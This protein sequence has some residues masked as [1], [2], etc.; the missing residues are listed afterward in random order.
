[1]PLPLF[2]LSPRAEWTR[3]VLPIDLNSGTRLSQYQPQGFTEYFRL[4][5]GQLEDTQYRL[6]SPNEMVAARDPALGEMFMRRSGGG[7]YGQ[8]YYSNPGGNYQG[9]SNGRPQ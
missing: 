4:K 8:R 3:S 5:H 9:G 7:D 6:V 1:M 2:T